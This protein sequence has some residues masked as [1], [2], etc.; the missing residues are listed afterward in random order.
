MGDE[1]AGEFEEGFVDVGPSFPADA[2]PFE[3]VEPGET[4]LDD[5]AVGSQPGAVEGAA[6]GDGRHD[7]ALPDLVAVDVVVVPSVGEE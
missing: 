1:T 3:A 7:A 4:A 2:E 5:P 6:A